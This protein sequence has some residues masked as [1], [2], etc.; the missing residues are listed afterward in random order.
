MILKE[1]KN[2][3]IKIDKNFCKECLI[4]YKVCP[5]KVFDKSDSG[6]I[7]VKDENSCIG[8]RICE[9]LCPDFAIEVEEL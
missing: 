7:F 2:F 8:C 6:L 3:S 9:N 4:C 5:K 1:Y